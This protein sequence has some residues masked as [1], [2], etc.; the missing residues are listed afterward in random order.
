MAEPFADI[1]AEAVGLKL[2]RIVKERLIACEGVRFTR[3][4][5]AV[6]TTLMR[7]KISGRAQ[8]E[9]K[10]EDHFV[11]VLDDDQSIVA[12][13]A[14]DAN[15]YRALKTRWMPCKVLNADD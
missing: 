2:H 6:V 12:T 13:V 10:I 1:P 3:G 4:R 15:S 8:I 9:G 14:L 5:A 7:A 11:D